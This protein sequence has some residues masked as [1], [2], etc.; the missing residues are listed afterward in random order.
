MKII[1]SPSKTQ[2][3]RIKSTD[4]KNIYWPDKTERLFKIIKEY[5]KEDLGKAMKIRGNL[6]EETFNLYRDWNTQME[7]IRAI[8]LYE[9]VAFEGIS[10]E[11]YNCEERKYME[12]NLLILSAMYGAVSPNTLIWP[13]RLDMT[14]KIGGE[15]LYKYWKEEINNLFKDEE[16]VVNLASN[17]FSKLLKVKNE[18]TLNIHFKNSLEGSKKRIS[19]Y[20]G[21]KARGQMVNNIIK[22]QLGEGEE[23][24]N[25]PPEGFIFNKEL[26]DPNNLFFTKTE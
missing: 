14:N 11:A 22:N 13:Y 19:S 2:N 24:K 9:G 23:I 3:T 8:D 7:K 1:M 18:K 6:L 20:E 26:S 12:D 15:N 10:S 21:K 17:E 4:G 25:Y 16:L 5:S